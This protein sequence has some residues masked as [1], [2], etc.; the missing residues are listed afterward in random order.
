MQITVIA[1]IVSSWQASMSKQIMAVKSAPVRNFGSSEFRTFEIASAG[2]SGPIQ[3]A[4]VQRSS[5]LPHLFHRSC[6]AYSFLLLMA[7]QFV[8]LTIM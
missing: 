6:G 7:G 4:L 3:R 5:K 2:F 1:W 8:K